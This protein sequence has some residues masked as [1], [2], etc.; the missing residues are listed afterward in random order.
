M[1]RTYPEYTDTR[2]PCPVA[3]ETVT[4]SQAWRCR[5]RPDGT[6]S[7]IAIRTAC[8]NQDRCV[9]A[10]HRAMSTSYDWTRCAFVNRIG[11]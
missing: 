1:S 9:V 10:T 6:V 7:R 11:S 5:R 4:V 2:F 8:D 3:R